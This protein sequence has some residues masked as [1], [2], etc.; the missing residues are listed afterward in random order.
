MLDRLVEEYR[1][2]GVGKEEGPALLADTAMYVLKAKN[3]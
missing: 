2:L 1:Y 3:S